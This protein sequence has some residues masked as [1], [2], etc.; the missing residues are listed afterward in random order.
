MSK[1]NF[2]KSSPP[3]HSFL[4]SV[5]GLDLLGVIGPRSPGKCPLP[6]DSITFHLNGISLPRHSTS[7]TEPPRST[8]SY[9]VL[10]FPL[11]VIAS[12]NHSLFYW[13]YPTYFLPVIPFF[14]SFFYIENRGS[15]LRF[16]ICSPPLSCSMLSFLLRVPNRHVFSYWPF[17][18]VPS[19]TFSS[20]ACR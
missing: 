14:P 13:I 3:R 4:D 12:A 11:H 7:H 19:F 2:F 1:S 17:W 20:Y 18:F 10:W 15:F 9:F 16:G 8:R 6:A 5:C